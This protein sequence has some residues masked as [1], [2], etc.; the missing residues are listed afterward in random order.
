MTNLI[1]LKI[2]KARTMKNP[3]K[4]S[5]RVYYEDTDAEG[6]VYYANY[7][8]FAERARSEFLRDR[9]LTVETKKDGER[10]V[11]VARHAEID[12]KQS[13]FL[14]DLLSVSCEIKEM[15]NSSAVIYQEV[16]R[17]DELLAVVTVTLVFVNINRHR[18][19]RIT[20]EMRQ[21]LQ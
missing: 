12:Y 15:K 20:E 7:L 19:T 8:K 16:K 17:G 10:C 18:P 3:F 9:K 11:F 6:V 14:D 13:A 2:L 5:V 4:I 21:K 1:Y